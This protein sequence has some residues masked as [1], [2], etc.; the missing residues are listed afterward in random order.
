MEIT[1]HMEQESHSLFDHIPV[2]NDFL[3]G[4]KPPY[5]PPKAVHYNGRGDE[6]TRFAY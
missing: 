4:V 5:F 1:K 3:I 2:R 6:G